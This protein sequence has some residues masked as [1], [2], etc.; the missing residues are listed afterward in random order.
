MNVSISTERLIKDLKLV[1][2]DAED[3]MRA[4]ASDVSEKAKEARSRLAATLDAAKLSCEALQDKAAAGAKAADKVIRDHP[5]QS[6]GVVFGVGLLIG[7]LINRRS[8]D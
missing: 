7:V 1:A 5:Y 8:R 3:L 6:L 2:R 4:T